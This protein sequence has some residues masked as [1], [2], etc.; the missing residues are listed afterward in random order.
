MHVSQTKLNVWKLEKIKFMNLYL[1]FNRDARKCSDCFFKNISQNSKVDFFKVI[2]SENSRHYEPKFHLDFDHMCSMQSDRNKNKM[3]LNKCVFN[4]LNFV[5]CLA[6]CKLR[7]CSMKIE[8]LKNCFLILLGCIC[9]HCLG[10]GLIRVALGPIDLRN[11][12][13]WTHA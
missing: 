1:S 6:R 13:P 11:V 10:E 4:V 9:T 8:Q 2:L 5:K 3:C 12:S 7:P